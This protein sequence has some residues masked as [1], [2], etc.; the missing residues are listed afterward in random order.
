MM[1]RDE[2]LEWAKQRAREYLDRNDWQQA[3]VSMVN[4]LNQHPELQK[5]AGIEMGAMLI[6]MPNS[7]YCNVSEMRRFIEGFR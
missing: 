1:T 4:D 3:W 5:H 2:H 7:N 6:M